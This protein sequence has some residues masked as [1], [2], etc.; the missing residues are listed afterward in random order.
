MKVTITKLVIGSQIGFLIGSG[1]SYLIFGKL[2]TPVIGNHVI[3]TLVHL[4]GIWQYKN[5]IK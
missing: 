4:L 5:L 3:I 1:I 2:S